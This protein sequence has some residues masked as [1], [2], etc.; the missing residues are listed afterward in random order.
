MPSAVVHFQF[1]TH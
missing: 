1:Y